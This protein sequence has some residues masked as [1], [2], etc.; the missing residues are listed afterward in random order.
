MTLTEREEKYKHYIEGFYDI[1][2]KVLNNHPEKV[3]E[4]QKQWD[5]RQYPW[6]FLPYMDI[7][8]NEKWE[9]K[10]SDSEQKV[11]KEF[12]WLFVN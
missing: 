8:L 9:E 4:F 6:A 7:Y 10:L 12:Y 1:A 3:A 11:H 5:E 2:L